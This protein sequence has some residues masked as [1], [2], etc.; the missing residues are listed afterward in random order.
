MIGERNRPVDRL[1][2]DD[3]GDAVVAQGSQSLLHATCRL[4]REAQGQ[5]VDEQE[6]W[7][8]DQGH[9][10]RQHVLLAAGEVAGALGGAL[11]EAREQIER[12]G[13]RGA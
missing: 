11:L 2:D 4:G 8:G 12:V 6:P 5:L 13:E 3:D 9:G 7:R 10:Q 1:L